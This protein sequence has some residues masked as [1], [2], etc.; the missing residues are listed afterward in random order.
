MGSGVGYGV[1][2]RMLGMDVSGLTSWSDVILVYKNNTY[3]HE[4][5]FK[6]SILV[7]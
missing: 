2:S 5:Y 4:H 6:E 1:V 7:H 3:I